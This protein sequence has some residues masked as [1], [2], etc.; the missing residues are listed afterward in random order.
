MKK[1]MIF[2]LAILVM[3]IFA[4]P[5]A[6]QADV[7]WG[8]G[9]LNLGSSANSDNE[10]SEYGLS[11]NVFLNYDVDGSYQAF[12]IASLHKAGNRNYATSNNTTLIYYETKDTG[13]TTGTTIAAGNTDWSA[14]V[15]M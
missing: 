1:I 13:A 3:G 8:T 4:M 14:W 10:P 15:S 6:A 2:A 9:V 12:G 11:N 7:T 5:N